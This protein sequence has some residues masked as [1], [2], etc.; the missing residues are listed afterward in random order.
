MSAEAVGAHMPA[1]LTLDDVA[2]MAA[3][4]EHHRYEL[5]AE[6]GLLVVPPAD[7]EHA[8][9]VARLFA[10]FLANGFGPEEVVVDCGV[11]VGGGRV[12]DLSVWA[13]G[14]PPR[15]GRSSY[16]GIDGLILAVEVVSAGSEAVDR[17]VKKVEYAKA[18]I[19]R[20]WLVERDAANSVI[21]WELAGGGEYV[22][23]PSGPRPLAW[24]LGTVPPPMSD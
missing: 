6:G 20:Y 24:L 1:H 23:A 13:S 21:R 18:G 22:Q 17:L 10:W 16:A 8:L 9:I 15:R 14:M 11:D 12:P 4:D 2:A 7:P 5:S 3:A 19:P